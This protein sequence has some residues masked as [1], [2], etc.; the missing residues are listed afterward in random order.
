[1]NTAVSAALVGSVLAQI[2]MTASANEL[3]VRLEG[4]ESREG[5]LLYAVFDTARPFPGDVDRAVRSG[6][7]PL[8]D[9]AGDVRLTIPLDPG[10]YAL[11]LVHDQNA[12]GQLDVGAFGIPV[13]GFGF[14]NN[15]ETRRGPPSFENSAFDFADPAEPIEI[16]IRY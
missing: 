5:A 2:A 11:A 8:E 16:I 12:N 3:T 1:M 14:S 13:E 4:L 9:G 6:Y 10:R 15:P 7:V